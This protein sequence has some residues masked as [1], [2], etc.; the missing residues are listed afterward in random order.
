MA[1]DQGSVDR[2]FTP[3]HRYILAGTLVK[4]RQ[5]FG[6]PVRFTLSDEL[7]DVVKAHAPKERK[8]AFGALRLNGFDIME[9]GDTGG[10]IGS[11]T[12]RIRCQVV[13]VYEHTYV[14]H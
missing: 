10:T 11:H 8:G 6:L 4:A 2:R 5:E 9:G 13:P 14:K 3:V 12:D 1:T 7:D